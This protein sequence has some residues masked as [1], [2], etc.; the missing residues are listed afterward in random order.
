MEYA[1]AKRRGMAGRD[2][3]DIPEFRNHLRSNGLTYEEWERRNKSATPDTTTEALKLRIKVL[4]AK[5]K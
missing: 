4:K 5:F 1:Y 2:I 3:R